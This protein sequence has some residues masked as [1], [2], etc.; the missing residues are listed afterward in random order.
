MQIEED[1]ERLS[2]ALDETRL[3]SAFSTNP[4]TAA[5]KGAHNE[6]LRAALDSAHVRPASSTIQDAC[7]GERYEV[8]VTRVTP[9][10]A[11]LW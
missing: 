8:P 7:Y 1:N 6:R 9:A 5:T 3:R 11:R 4:S 10:R 2:A